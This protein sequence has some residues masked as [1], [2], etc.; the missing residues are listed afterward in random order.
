MGRKGRKRPA[1]AELLLKQVASEFRKKKEELHSAKRA[2][3]EL[4]VCPASFYKYMAGENVPDMD[5]LRA[6][7]DKWGIK[8]KHLDPSEVLRPLKMKTAEQ[9]VF[10]FLN[11]LHEEDIEVVEVGPEGNSVL[12]ISLKIRFPAA[13]T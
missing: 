3:K 7:T 10:S 9:L 12:H 5:V 13:K 6:A 2:A 4:G 1:D 11:A 8:W